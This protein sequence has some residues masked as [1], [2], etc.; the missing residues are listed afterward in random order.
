MIVDGEW[1]RAMKERNSILVLLVMAC[2]FF[3]PE[4]SYAAS[5]AIAQDGNT[6]VGATPA[7]GAE[8][9]VELSGETIEPAASAAEPQPSDANGESVQKPND[10][11]GSPVDPA[12]EVETP[13]FVEGWNHVD[14]SWYFVRGGSP[15]TGWQQIRGNWYWF[16][17]SEN[18]KMAT[19]WLDVAGARYYLAESGS[20]EGAMA[21]GWIRNQ[22]AWYFANQSGAILSNWQWIGGAWYWFDP[23]CGCK[24][25][26]GLNVI[27]GHEYLLGDYGLANGWVLDGA[28]WYYGSNGEVLNGWQWINGAWYYL[29][30]S[31][32]GAMATGWNTISGVRYYLNSSGAMATGWILQGDDWYFAENSGAIVTGWRFVNGAWYWLEPSDDGKMSVGFKDVGSSRYYLASSGEMKTGWILVGNDWYYADSSGAFRA[33]WLALGEHWYYLNPNGEYKMLTGFFSVGD[34]RYYAFDSGKMAE[35]Q[36]VDMGDGSKTFAGIDGALCGKLEN[37]MLYVPDSEGKLQLASGVVTLGGC[38]FNVDPVTHTVA[39]G[40]KNVDG[41]WYYF[42]ESGRACFGWIFEGGSWYYL[43][44]NSGAMATGWIND[45]GTWYYADSSGSMRTGWLNLGGTWY[46]LDGSGAMATGWRWI[47]GTWYCFKSSGEWIS[48]SM[49]AKAQGYYSR[50]N[51]LILVDTSRCITSVYYGSQGNWGLYKRYV[52]S[53]GRAATPTV[54]GEYEV[55]GK[56]YSFGHGYTCYWYTQFYGDYLFHSSPYYVNSNRIMDATMGVP[57]SA[58]CV[59]LEIQNAKWIYDNIPYGTKVVTY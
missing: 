18:G 50:T 33:G 37:G 8:S 30:P 26:R 5:S 6:A 12:P 36:W 40:W 17:A 13:A 32:K 49:N 56:G 9:S 41:I 55:Y 23:S 58:G 35:R 38:K 47:D 4:I 1:G 39:S 54:I 51:W 19:G 20:A 21:T 28:L 44:K 43:D 52:C 3:M 7:A 16:D 48:D 24:M 15:L 2:A 45:G 46:W 14:A 22:G 11:S 57:S 42:D 53:T 27:D 29:N 10:S 34:S 31:E 59:R 25:A